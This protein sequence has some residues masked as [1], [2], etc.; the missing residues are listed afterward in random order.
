VGTP[1]DNDETFCSA[2]DGRKGIDTVEHLAEHLAEVMD[3]DSV[4]VCVGN[5]LCGD[6]GAGVAVAEKLEKLADS[7]PWRVFNTQTVPESFLMKIVD[8]K[9][10]SIVLVD[11]LDFGGEGGAVELIQ[12]ADVTGQGPSTHGPAP[13][14]FLDV[15][16]LFHPC[17]QAVLGIQAKSTEVGETISEPVSRAVDMVVRAFQIVAGK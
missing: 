8:T 12:A 4:I 5:D 10:S 11:A 2:H 14:A 7:V 6:D 3:S 15:I 16:K 9:P 1:S 17:R 13:L